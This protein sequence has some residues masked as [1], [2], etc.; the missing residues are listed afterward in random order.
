MARS[1]SQFAGLKFLDNNTRTNHW[2]NV[3]GVSQG[4]VRSYSWSWLKVVDNCSG[5]IEA[6]VKGFA[7]YSHDL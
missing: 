7:G 5:R 4:T 2:L 3:R 6:W 1:I